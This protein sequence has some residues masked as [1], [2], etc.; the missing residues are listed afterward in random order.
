MACAGF[1]C[2]VSELVSVV[3]DKIKGADLNYVPYDFLK[4]FGLG[5]GIYCIQG[6]VRKEFMNHHIAEQSSYLFSVIAR[7]N[8]Y[9]S[10]FFSICNPRVMKIAQ[11]MGSE[12]I[13]TYAG[14][15]FPFYF[16][17]LNLQPTVIKPKL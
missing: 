2:D 14:F 16:M 8:G 15:K 11:K 13:S 5:E 1:S 10:L 9:Q 7:K 3:R 6:V 12:I 17:R 4:Q